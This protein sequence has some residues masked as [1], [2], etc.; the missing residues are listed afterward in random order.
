M[1]E[2]GVTAPE[3]IPTVADGTVPDGMAS[4]GMLDGMASDG[5]LDGIPLHGTPPDG[6]APNGMAPNGIPVGSPKGILEGVA[7]L[8]NW[9]Q[10]TEEGT[11]IVKW[12]T[13]VHWQGL[14]RVT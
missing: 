6:M 13:M 5:M 11:P 14:G 4:D 8:E 9:E 3:R 2:E 7:L 12:L 1:G 10:G